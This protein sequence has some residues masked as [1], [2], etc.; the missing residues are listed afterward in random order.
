MRNTYLVVEVLLLM[1]LQIVFWNFLN[2][3]QLVVLCF[4]P[5]I[6]LC[7]PIDTRPVISMLLAVA[8]SF[9]VDFFS[10]GVMGL[11]AVALLP[12]AYLRPF[13]IRLVFG[14]ELFA[15]DED[16]SFAGQGVMKMMLAVS[17]CTILFFIIYVWVDSAGT[18]TGIFNLARLVLSSIVSI[19]VSLGVSAV[20]TSER[21]R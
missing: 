14:S 13:I 8:I 2:L 7:L 15:R 21:W 12:V 5:A 3:S 11:T 20:L 10:H 9:I 19:L 18:R 16:I 6:I 1:L 17:I 4:L